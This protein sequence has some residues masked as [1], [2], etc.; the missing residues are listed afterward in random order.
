MST[1]CTWIVRVAEDSTEPMIWPWITCLETTGRTSHLSRWLLPI[2]DRVLFVFLR[3][4]INTLPCFWIQFSGGNLHSVPP[5]I[6]SSAQTNWLNRGDVRKALHIPDT[7][8]PWDICRY[9][10]K[11]CC[12]SAD[13]TTGTANDPLCLLCSDIVGYR[14]KML[15][16]TMKEVYLKLVSLGLRALVYNGDTDMACNFLGDQW[17]VEDL[18]L[19]V[20]LKKTKKLKRLLLKI[21]KIFGCFLLFVFLSLKNKNQTPVLNV[22]PRGPQITCPG[23]RITRLLVSTSSLETSLSWQW[24]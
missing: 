1:P 17:F 23:F 15:Y 19:Q 10:C 6:N 14:Y 9:A 22:I 4:L 7:L 20:I 11:E 2:C 13:V 3:C 24:R 18:G 8:P 12:E 21:N 5:C 16:E